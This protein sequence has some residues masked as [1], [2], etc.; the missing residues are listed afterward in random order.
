MEEYSKTILEE[1]NISSAFAEW[2][3][4]LVKY[5]LTKNIIEIL[6]NIVTA[7]LKIIGSKPSFIPSATI[8]V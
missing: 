3:I 1:M 6:E 4:D 5:G 8:I 2:S 7:L